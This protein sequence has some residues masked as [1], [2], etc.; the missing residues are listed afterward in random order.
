MALINTKI[1]FSVLMVEKLAEYIFFL[2]S[3]I[4][5][6]LQFV[7]MTT[8]RELGGPV[9]SALWRAIE[10]T[11]QR[12]QRLVIGWVTNI[13]YLELLRASEGT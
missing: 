7:T 3:A 9:V 5:S 8:F 4:L 12:S 13:Y 1:F 10:E 11:K 2:F 6:A